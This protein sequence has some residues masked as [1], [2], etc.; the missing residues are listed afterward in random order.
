MVPS[1]Y[2]I[3][4]RHDGRPQEIT[5]QL[6]GTSGW[7]V[8]SDTGDV[9]RRDGYWQYE[10]SPSNRSNEF[11]HLTRFATADDAFAAFKAFGHP[12]KEQ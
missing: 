4:R 3:V 10:P 9:M 5:I 7:A 2:N 6:R 11:V 8:V 1:K 12:V